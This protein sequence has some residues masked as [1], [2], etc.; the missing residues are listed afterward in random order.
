MTTRLDDWLRAA[1]ACVELRDAQVLAAHALG[2]DRAGLI[3]RGR[4]VLDPGRLAQM[5]CLLA[6]RAAGEPVAYLVGRREFYGLDL[7]VAPGVLIPRPETELL[8]D[9]ALERIRHL[10]APRVLDAG[11]G[12]GAIALAIKAQCPQARVMALDRSEPALAIAHDNARRL[13]LEVAFIVSNW[14]DAVCAHEFDCIVSNPPYI[15]AA[16]PHLGQGDL[17]FEPESALASG[18]DGQDALRAL[19]ASAPMRLAAGGWMLC[20][21]GYDQA[22]AVRVLMSGAGLAD[23]ASWRDIAGI[24]RVSGGM[25]RDVPADGRERI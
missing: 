6:R 17:R 10:P 24:E 7:A 5:D 11:T 4:D 13:G 14:L 20:E 2:C 19:C 15:R 8:V 23:V 1:R 18:A 9:L 22:P 3:A 12:S 25:R 16:D 21:H